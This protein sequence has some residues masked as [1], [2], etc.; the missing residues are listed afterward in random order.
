VIGRR[1]LLA[2]TILAIG[3]ALAGL[4]PAWAN[5]TITILNNDGPGEGFN[6]GTP[7][8]PV[9]GNPGTT[10]GQQR[11]IAFQFAADIW[12]AALDSNVE[13]VIRSQF[14]PLACDATSAVVGS[15]GT[16]YLV[17]D[18]ADATIPPFPGPAFSGVLYHGALGDSRAGIELNPG[19]PDMSAT[20]NSNLGQPGCATGAF[21]YYGLDNEAGTLVD[22]VA[23]LLHEFSHGLGF[24]Q[25][26]NLS[27]GA[28]F[29]GLPDIYNRQL[30]DQ[31]VG[32]S[33]DQ[34]SNAQRVASAVRA[35]HVVW[36]GPTVA[37]QVPGILTPGTP[38]VRV[39]TPPAI[40]TDYPVG[41]A[42]FG[43]PLG[44]PGTNKSFVA[45]LD[46]NNASGPL[47][48]DACTALTNAAS[49]TGKIALVDR[50]TCNFTVKVKNC[51]NAGA[52][53][54][55][56]ADNV[57]QAPPPGMSGT[58]AT[59]TIPSVMVTQ[60]DG[61]L[62][63]AQLGSG[64]TGQMVFDAQVYQGADASDQMFVFTPQPLI[65]GSSVSHW[66]D[67]ATP[68]LLM[69]P[70]LNPGLAHQVEG[71]DLSLAL[72]RDVGW[73]ADADTDGLPDT[74]DTDD[75]NDG[76]ADGGDCAPLDA[77]AFAIPVEIV[78]LSLASITSMSWSSAAS[79][80]GSDTVYDVVR[81]SIAELPVSSG[82]STT[83]LG[84]TASTSFT[85]SA[86]PASGSGFWY[87]VRGTNVCGNGGY[88]TRSNG[89][90]NAPTVCD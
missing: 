31:V 5:A 50:G 65:G 85:V 76:V 17:S 19:Q 62:I 37:A 59:I 89:T 9:G 30:F 74:T 3:L 46:Q 36:S 23:T 8:A 73:V 11:L 24:S 78:G 82:G 38:L 88:G 15:T 44:A 21:F 18:F 14:N 47:L 20:F 7:A 10:I 84:Q 34:M 71:T 32:L 69:E 2:S 63:R 40:D 57:A 6:D 26:A 12:G 41:L 86:S 81:G 1:R 66:D 33:W 48:T 80:S 70:A 52:V 28:L 61:A 64:V 35:R 16:F 55:V 90:P 42:L 60:A 13:M 77:G 58:D 4:A 51:Q 43:P 25:F 67:S 49:V 72:M 56:V 75:D 29:S 68:N 27:T 54:V 83:C 53:G 22:L 45:A 79:G 87:L 39:A